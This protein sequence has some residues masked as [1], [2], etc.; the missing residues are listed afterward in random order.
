MSRRLAT[1]YVRGKSDVIE[2]FAPYNNTAIAEGL[3]VVLHTDGTVKAY[4]G[5][6]VIMG[7]SGMKEI[8]KQSVIRSG[9]DVLVRIASGITVASGDA[10]YV[11]SAGLFTNVS[12]DNTAVNATFRSAKETAI[13]NA[14]QSYDAAAIDFAGGL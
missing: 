2:N 10:V 1:P 7:V 11:T 14:G 4:A 3:A 8:K 6:G 5:S 9:L 13:D 12:T